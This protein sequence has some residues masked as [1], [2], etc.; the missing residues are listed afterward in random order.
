MSLFTRPQQVTELNWISKSIFMHCRSR[1]REQG[2]RL[3][4][5]IE[6]DERE[7]AGRTVSR[8]AA[9]GD[10]DGSAEDGYA[11]LCPFCGLHG[12]PSRL[13]TDTPLSCMQGGGRH[14]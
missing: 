13:F 1:G 5:G 7:Y 3:R 8:A 10:E 9:F 11:A 2:L 6:L 14:R 4:H 12:K